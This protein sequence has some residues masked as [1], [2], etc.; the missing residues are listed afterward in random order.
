LNVDA[1]AIPDVVSDIAHAPLASG[2]FDEVYF[3][4]VP[5]HVFASDDDVALREAARV[6][7][8]GGRLVIETGWAA[9]VS[10]IRAAMRRT[11]IRYVRSK[12]V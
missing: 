1:D 8:P 2:V 10:E 9:P 6:L 5:Y 4:K 3:E 7:R 11:G 12:N